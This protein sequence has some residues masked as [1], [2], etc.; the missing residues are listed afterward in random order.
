M[1][2]CRTEVDASE[3]LRT[4]TG[5]GDAVCSEWNECTK[6]DYSDPAVIAGRVSLAR[7]CIANGHAT[8]GTAQQEKWGEPPGSFGAPAVFW[9]GRVV[10]ALEVQWFPALEL[11]GVLAQGVARVP[12]LKVPH[13]R[14]PAGRDRA[15]SVNVR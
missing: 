4:R 9:F 12:G 3:P 14:N 6:S 15:D 13:R 2:G 7:V 11:I 10:P 5:T 1:R 8:L